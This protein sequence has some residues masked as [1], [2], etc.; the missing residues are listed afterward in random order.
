MNLLLL[1]HNQIFFI[2]QKERNGRKTGKKFK[3][4]EYMCCLS[5]LTDLKVTQ[6]STQLLVIFGHT[7]FSIVLEIVGQ[8]I[9]KK[10]GS[11]LKKSERQ[12]ISVS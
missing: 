11:L 4:D 12:K 2:E 6:V 9:I 7:I 8:T 10:H 3:L 5:I 1:W